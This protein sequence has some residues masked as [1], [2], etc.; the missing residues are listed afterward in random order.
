MLD[1]RA[2]RCWFVAS[3][4]HLDVSIADDA[5]LSVNFGSDGVHWLVLVGCRSRRREELPTH[6]EL[7]Q[8]KNAELLKIISESAATRLNTRVFL[9]QFVV[10]TGI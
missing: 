9:L 10:E 7:T 2:E 3:L 8:Q 1:L 6:V 5:C 4:K